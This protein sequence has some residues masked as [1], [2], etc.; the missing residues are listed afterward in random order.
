MGSPSA[1]TGGGGGGVGPAGMTGTTVVAGKRKKT[2]GT[3][4]DAK[5]VLKQGV[6][7]SFQNKPYFTKQGGPLILKPAEPLFDAGSKKTRT[8]FTDKVLASD[9]AKKNIGYTKDEFLKL[10]TKKREK[11]YKGYLDKRLTNKTDA[12]GNKLNINSGPDND[13][14]NVQT[15]P[16]ATIMPVPSDP[17][18][19]ATPLDPQPS[20]TEKKYDSRKTKKKG[21][22]QNLLTSAKGVMKTS[23]DY[24]LG[25]KSLLGQVV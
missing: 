15:P 12:Y 5:N 22:N 19:P 10:S 1:S 20:E 3:A 8:F 13:P 7:T 25:K 21:R 2:Y 9:K 16:V 17:N 14:T 11:V 24:S 23:A 18:A 6:V 4:Q